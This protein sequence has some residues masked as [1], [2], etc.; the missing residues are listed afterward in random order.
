[1]FLDAC[2]GWPGSVHDARMWKSSFIYSCLKNG[3][4]NVGEG[5]LL[6]DSAY[7]LDLFIMTPFKDNGHLTGREI[8]YNKSQSAAR[9]M[10]ERAFALLKGRFR[11]L[12]YLDMLLIAEISEV[13]MSCCIL[14]N[15]V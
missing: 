11:R 2:A 3:S 15:F 4:R 6:G 9:Q 13:I 5:H 14:H 8:N 7:P 12:K 1:M 10:L